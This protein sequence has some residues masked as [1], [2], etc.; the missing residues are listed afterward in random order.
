MNA[1]KGVKS[2][3]EVTLRTCVSV[4]RLE[5]EDL[6]ALLCAIAEHDEEGLKFLRTFVDNPP[7]KESPE[8]AKETVFRQRSLLGDL[9]P[10]TDQTSMDS[11]PFTLTEV[12]LAIV[13]ASTSKIGDNVVLIDP[14][15]G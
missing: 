10:F 1:H 12:A 15:K 9:R 8:T 14:I 2:M 4:P 3:D 5:Y 13:K 11:C 7:T 6:H